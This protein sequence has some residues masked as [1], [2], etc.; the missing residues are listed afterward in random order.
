M[1][2]CRL[3]LSGDTDPMFLNSSKVPTDDTMLRYSDFHSSA[4]SVATELKL[5]DENSMRFS[6]SQLLMDGRC[7]ICSDKVSGYH[8]GLQTCESCKGR[9]AW[10]KK[11]CNCNNVLPSNF[12]LS[13]H[14][15][16]TNQSFI[17]FRIITISAFFKLAW[18]SFLNSGASGDYDK[19][20]N[21]FVYGKVYVVKMFER[22]IKITQSMVDHTHNA[23]TKDRS[24][25]RD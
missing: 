24:E 7:P 9:V 8:Y 3:F 5:E 4:S 10:T 16:N 19:H 21:S 15:V 13:D 18:C 20:S 12:A 2:R 23:S 1:D 22:L 6:R 11:C 14:T 25:S 17:D